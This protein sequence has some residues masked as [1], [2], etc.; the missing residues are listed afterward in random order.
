MVRML[1]FDCDGGLPRAAALGLIV[2][3]A[4]E[5]LEAEVSPL[6][7]R[8]GGSLYHSRIASAPD[9]TTETLMEMKTHLASAAALLP[10]HR[11][12]DVIG[13][14]CTSASTLIGSNAVA[15]A[16]RT[17]HPDA[18]VTDPARAVIA[19][20][21]YQGARR[22]ALVSPYIAPVTD[23][24]CGLLKGEG[25]DPVSVGTFGQAEE[26][27]VARISPASVF[28][29]VKALGQDKTI[30]A[31]FAS[32]TNLRSFS[33]IE[34]C[35]RTIGKPVISSNLALAWHMLQLAGLPTQGCGPGRLFS[36]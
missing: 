12:L 34:D 6:L 13:Y 36:S 7:L 19:A 4:D 31:V 14:G 27:V 17:A 15:A 16:I 1:D 22:I 11:P 18:A 32:C 30:D 5:T 3:Q 23:A 9:V 2:L 20:L 8:Q 21:T 29:A 33:V 28:E 26:K 10:G 24:V 35:E 25:I